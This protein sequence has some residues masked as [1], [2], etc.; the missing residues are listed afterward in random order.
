MSVEGGVQWRQCG[1]CT[2]RRHARHATACAR[3]YYYDELLLSWA[4][5]A[6]STAGDAPAALTFG[7]FTN[8]KKVP[9]GHRRE[10]REIMCGCVG[11]TAPASPAAHRHSEAPTAHCFSFDNLVYTS[12]K[13]S[14]S[15]SAGGRLAGGQDRETMGVAPSAHAR[16]HAAAAENRRK[17][18]LEGVTAQTPHIFRQTSVDLSRS[19]RELAMAVSKTAAV[20]A[21]IR[22]FYPEHALSEEQ[23]RSL[24]KGKAS[25]AYK[26][27]PVSG[28]AVGRKEPPLEALDSNGCVNINVKVC[29][30]LQSRLLGCRNWRNCD[31]VLEY[32]EHL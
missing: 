24:N 2:S 11:A 16:H 22:P 12:S 23:F 5:A 17:R 18:S 6:G 4:A 28:F 15:S 26:V 10:R 19:S 13:A 3:D 30:P 25:A 32:Q 20:D 1:R 7:S 31:T 29:Q 8:E 14:A 9:S 21:S 27:D